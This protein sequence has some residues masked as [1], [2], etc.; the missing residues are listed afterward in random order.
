MSRATQT[1]DRDAKP[2]WRPSDTLEARI[3]MPPVLQFPTDWTLSTSWQRAQQEPDAG[4][5][6]NDAERMVYL[7]ESSKPHR[8]VFVLCD[9][10]LRAECS[11]SGWKFHGFCAHVA[12]LWWRWTRGRIT[13]RHLRTGRAYREPPSWVRVD[14]TP[15]ADLQALTPA[16]LDAYLHCELGSSG[17][18]EWA[19][20]TDRA[21]GTI[22]NLLRTAREKLPDLHAHTDPHPHAGGESDG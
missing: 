4:G 2:D 13:V 22:G 7:E 19:D 5:P 1:H 8:V 20:H 3:G 11:C 17:P 21:K 9:R 12:S 6:I 16:E 18:T 10:T 14:C 15:D